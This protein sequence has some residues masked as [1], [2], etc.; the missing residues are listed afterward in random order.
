M[1]GQ[2]KQHGEIGNKGT[3]GTKERRKQIILF[4]L[5]DGSF[6]CC[7]IRLTGIKFQPPS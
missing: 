5:L 2:E 1:K 3:K 7:D 6:V 4:I